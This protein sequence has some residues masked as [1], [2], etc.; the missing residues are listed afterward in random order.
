MPRV[1]GSSRPE[2]ISQALVGQSKKAHAEY[3]D[4]PLYHVSYNG[5][6]GLA[7]LGRA[8]PETRRRQRSR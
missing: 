3:D 5:D 1:D 8:A 6:L 4:R 7:S 2:T